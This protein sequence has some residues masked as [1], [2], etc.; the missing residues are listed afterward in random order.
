MNHFFWVILPILPSFFS[1]VPS[2]RSASPAS[3]SAALIASICSSLGPSALLVSWGAGATDA[4]PRFRR[5]AV[6]AA[7]VIAASGHR[8]QQRDS[9]SCQLSV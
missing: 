5:L 8:R 6:A 4:F 7:D 9:A 2:V 1:Y 3:A